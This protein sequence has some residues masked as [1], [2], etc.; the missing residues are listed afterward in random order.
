M[1]GVVDRLK[2]SASHLLRTKFV[3]SRSRLLALWSC[4]Y[5]ADRVGSAS[6]AAVRRCI[7]GQKK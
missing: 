5:Y 2:G 1:A 6:A 7:E 4:S 3:S